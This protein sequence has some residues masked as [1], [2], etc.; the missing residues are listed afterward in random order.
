MFE[1]LYRKETL[2]DGFRIVGTHFFI[3][4]TIEALKL[5][6]PLHQ[7]DVVHA[8]IKRIQQADKSGMDAKAAE[9]TFFVGKRTWKSSVTW[10]AGAIAHDAYHSELYIKTRNLEGR[11]LLTRSQQ[12]LYADHG[13][14][15]TQS[16][17]A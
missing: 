17:Y 7:Y 6:Q 1:K 4:R 8:G 10:Y 11:Y 14:G 2:F 3:N 9:P 15:Q 5:L 13:A 12:G 16:V